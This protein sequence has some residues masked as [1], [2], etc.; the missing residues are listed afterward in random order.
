MAALY[1]NVL[2]FNLKYYLSIPVIFFFACVI[3]TTIFASLLSPFFDV[4]SGV[5]LW[6]AARV[7]NG[8]WR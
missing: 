2:F 3:S 1:T 4:Y 8:Y 5:F 6:R 7:R